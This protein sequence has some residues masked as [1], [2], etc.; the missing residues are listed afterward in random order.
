M[1]AKKE[2]LNRKRQT[3][4]RQRK[5]LSKSLDSAIREKSSDAVT[6]VADQ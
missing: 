6:P 2:I 3:G 1:A 4:N 5:S